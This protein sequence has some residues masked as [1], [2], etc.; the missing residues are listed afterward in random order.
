MFRPNPRS[1]RSRIV[2][3][4]SALVILAL[5]APANPAAL[6]AAENAKIVFLAGPKD[7]G[8][9]G[10]HEYEKDLRVL[11]NGLETSSN[12]APV[13]TRVFVGKAPR[14]LAE[15]RGAAAIVIESS[16]DRWER[17]VHPLFPP[18]PLTNHRNHDEETT[19]WLKSL[20]ELIT[21]QQTGVV[22]FHYANWAEN[23]AARGYHMKWLG[24]LWVQMVSRNPVDQWA[25]TLEA[26]EHPILRGVQPWTYRDEIFCR[27]HLPTDPRRTP[28]LLATPQE[29]K[30]GIG[31]Q[32]AA[33][34]YQ[35]DDGGR[36]FV[37]GGVDFHDNMTV[38][39]YRKFL[40]NGI[41]WAARLEVPEGGVAS[42]LPAD[43][44]VEHAAE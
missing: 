13:T 31:A 21:A 44:K 2:V 9:P 41:A 19:A 25:I 18:D 7:H 24:G 38:E 27:F 37:F 6:V 12:L 35:R 42:T 22:V 30:F 36:G 8:R 5:A 15:Y 10:R 1:A 32:I 17:E 11:A 4:C 39:D 26:P 28:L 23:W 33:W 16:S 43:F 29:D 14:D 34:A 3:V 20:D 40:L